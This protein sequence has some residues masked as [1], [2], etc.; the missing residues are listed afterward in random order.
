MVVGMIIRELGRGKYSDC[1]KV[2]DGRGLAIAFKLS[3]YQEAT[4]RAFAR[5]AQHGDRQA[6]HVAK[7]Q[8]A[9]SVSTSMAE[10]AKQMK[11]HDVS[12]H[13]VRVYCEA[14]VRYL[15]V[16]LKPLLRDRLSQ[17]TPRQVKYSHVCMMELY[18]CNLT[19]LLVHGTV[20]DKMLRPLL[21]HVIYTLACLQE[22]FPGF[23][24]NDL[25]PN[26]V[27][28]KPAKHKCAQY[29]I[30]KMAFFVRCPLTAVL[31]DFDF[32]HVPGHEV[33]SNERVLSGNYGINAHPNDAYDTHLLLKGVHKCLLKH[34]GGCPETV[35]FIRSLRLDQDR[36]RIQEGMPH[37]APLRLL[38]HVYFD[39]LRDSRL[40]S[41][42]VKRYALPPM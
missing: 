34:R 29:H 24:H 3:Y 5:H 11:L 28:I 18:S 27:L 12:P 14:D 36:E 40:A 41:R 9:I 20:S 17:L 6:A 38:G 32:T 1:F 31:A 30:R 4:I 10:V 26:N 2:K 7:E 19:R 22:V 25:S 39:S 42:C 37:L 33:L 23:R 35:R 13:F 15:P 8:D 16:R 21:F